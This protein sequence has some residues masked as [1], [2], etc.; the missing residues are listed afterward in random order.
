[1]SAHGLNGR[2]R[3]DTAARIAADIPDGS[4]VNLGIGAPELVANFVP[5]GR[6]II[7][8]SENGILG[9]GP[10]PNDNEIDWELVNAGKKPV[11][12]VPGS[13]LFDSADSF[14]MIR[15]QHLDYCVLGAFQVS[16]RG[17]LANWLTNA[18]DAIPAVGGAMDLGA[19]ARNVIVFTDHCT[20][21]GAPKIV[22]SCSY[23]LT[24]VGTVTAVYTDLCV[25]DITA[26]GLVVRE[27]VDGVSFADLQ[28]VTGAP[29]TLPS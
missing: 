21:S 8:H 22:D 11:T 3:A 12:L 17:D 16:A 2:S 19:G 29:L 27:L 18:D 26:E 9:M 25:I 13:S 7:F 5:E 23:P 6:E 1:M 28:N 14:G 10:S 20:R 24:T 4:Y 15:G